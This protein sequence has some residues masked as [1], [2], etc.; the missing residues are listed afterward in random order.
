V[1]GN[2]PS[3]AEVLTLTTGFGNFST[4][5]KWIGIIAVV[6]AVI[7][8]VLILGRGAERYN[9]LLISIDTCRADH[10]GCYGYEPIRTP[11]IDR[12]AE[13]GFLFKKATSEVPLT[14]PSHTCILTGLLPITNGVRDNGTFV[15]SDQFTTLAEMFS[16]EGYSTGAFVATFV[17][18]SR[19]GLAQGF[20]AYS[21]DMESGSQKSAFLWPERRADAVN[22]TALKW[23]DEVRE[24]FF[25]FVHY[26]DPHDPYDP[27]EPYATAYA[28]SPYDG[29]IAYTDSMLGQLLETLKRNGEYDNTL[30]VLV[31]DHGEGLNEHDEPGHGVLVYE[32]TLHVVMIMKPPKGLDLAGKA[33]GSERIDYPVQLVDVYPT[34]LD[35]VGI[36]CDH[37]VDGESLV[38]V[39]QGGRIES[40]MLYFESLY[41][42]FYFKWSQLRGI[43]HNNWK[44]ILAPE[45][46]LYDLAADPHELVNLATSQ[47]ERVAEM[48]GQLNRIAARE[49]EALETA[50]QSLTQEEVRKLMA[51]GYIAGGQ[52]KLPADITAEGRDPKYMMGDLGTYLWGGRD[53]F[54]AGRFDEA[55]GMFGQMVL[56]DPGNPQAHVHLAKALMELGEV[57]IAQK[58]FRKAIEIDSTHSG[59]F[60]PM[61][62]IMRQRGNLDRALFYLRLGA[63]MSMETPDVLSSMG[64]VYV[65]KGEPDSAIAVLE[66]A[67]ELDP[68]DPM[69]FLNM[70]LAYMHK[71]DP[72]EALHWFRATIGVQP[73]NVKALVN[74]ARIFIGRSRPDSTIHYFE[75]AREVAPTDPDILANLG[76]AY[77]Q[78]GMIEQAGEAYEAALQYQSDNVTAM[79]GLAA[80]RAQQGRKEESIA[81]LEQ[82][83]EIDPDF[84]AALRALQSL[85]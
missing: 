44:Y 73:R 82:I 85:K 48:R 35:L 45:E 54:D 50:R 22:D 24:P 51:L 3:H 49:A 29:E 34:I 7:I 84:Q 80:V 8:L 36:E 63:S 74:I 19:F 83:L 9:V 64:A 46:E 11:N 57:D 66:K 69:A 31:S 71:N 25:A 72:E 1:T 14:L 42:Y 37:E 67:L 17:L 20:E 15:L 41:A 30:I 79:F 2:Q 43:R 32:S 21:D 53:L 62:N 6:A 78:N 59:A 26:Y 23:F 77:R 38:P 4:M 55:A 56:K 33:E 12:L 27:P 76:S 47:P 40:R 58:E 81:L 16:E 5:G 28:E 13:E 52:P 65:E 75:L 39:M 18:D 61:A 10:L 68:R 60:F 70:G